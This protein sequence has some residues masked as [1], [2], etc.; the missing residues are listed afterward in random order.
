MPSTMSFSVRMCQVS[1]GFQSR[2]RHLVQRQHRVVAGVVGVVAGWPV[3]GLAT[4]AQ[5][6]VVRD[7]DRLVVGDHPGRAAPAPSASRSARACRRPAASGRSQRRSRNR[8]GV[9]PGG[10][11]FSWVPQPSSD[12]CRPSEMKPSTDQ[13]L[14]NLPRGFGI[15]C[16]L[17]IAF[18]DV[19]ALDADPLHQP[20]PLLARAGLLVRDADDRAATSSSACLTIQETMPGLAPQQL[21]AVMP[22]GRRRRRSRTLSRR[23]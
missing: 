14:T 9:P 2:A 19:D 23:A 6:E 22:P 3:D 20:R 11:V 17:G 12:G 21:T 8:G 15:A 1:C 13:V 5:R 10:S 4:F 7:R 16:P 18:G